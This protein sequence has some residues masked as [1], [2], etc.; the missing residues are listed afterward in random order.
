MRRLKRTYYLGFD[1]TSYNPSPRKRR[2]RRYAKNTKTSIVVSHGATKENS[3]KSFKFRFEVPKNWK[4]ILR[5]DEAAGNSMW[6]DSVEKEVSSLIHHECFNF[7]S[8]DYKPS[9]DYQYCRLHLV[10]DI[11]LDLNY[12]SRL[13]CD[14]SKVDP[15]GLSTRATVVK[16]ISVRLLDLI[17]DS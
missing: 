2:S 12:K 15:R 17:T 6:Q 10:Y 4:E 14:G 7:K 5:I 11:N 3:K 1:A 16:E 8:S 13:A 9:D